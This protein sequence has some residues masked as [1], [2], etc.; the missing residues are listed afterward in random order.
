MNSSGTESESDAGP[1]MTYM[2]RQEE[3]A[4]RL[5]KSEMCCACYDRFPLHRVK[6]L[7]CAHF[8]CHS[9]LKSLFVKVTADKLL[10]PSKCCGKPIPLYLVQAEMSQHEFDEFKS[11]D[12]EFSTTERTYCSS[13][14]CGKF[15]PP[16][17]IEADRAI[18][19]DCG[20]HM[21]D[22]SKCLPRQR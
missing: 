1:S 17:S 6:S 4:R 14:G 13:P 21:C 12:D 2:Q 11:A 7:D 19:L 15:I 10:F 20:N 9:C 18:C 16:E 22:V 8:Y 5:W 3:A